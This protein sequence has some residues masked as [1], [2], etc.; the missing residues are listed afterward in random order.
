MVGLTLT[1]AYLGST[2]LSQRYTFQGS[3]IEPSIPAADF[4]LT[5]QD[6]QLF[7][8]SDQRGKVALL[9]F[10][11]TSCPDVCP[12]TLA[13]FKH[14]FNQLQGRAEQVR[15]VF[16]TTD[17]NRDTPGRLKTY[18]G[19]FDPSFVGLS[20]DLTDLE[21]VWRSYGV[22]RQKQDTGSETA[23]L[24]DHTSSVYVIDSAGNLG[25]TFPYGME[26]EAMVADLLHLLKE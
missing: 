20:G 18:L 10:G 8:L 5:D 9:F 22:F 2:L 26:R 4:A 3:V 17:P 13:D 7:Q 15:F 16:V 6:G 14:V 1:I 25:M 23:Y 11:Y 21:E 24:V 19:L 12:T